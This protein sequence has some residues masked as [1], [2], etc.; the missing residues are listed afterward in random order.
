M[1]N[2]NNYKVSVSPTPFSITALNGQVLTALPEGPPK[3]KSLFEATMHFSV[4]TYSFKCTPV[5]LHYRGNKFR[6]IYARLHLYECELMLMLLDHPR[7]AA[8]AENVRIVI[9]TNLFLWIALWFNLPLI[10]EHN[11]TASAT[12]ILTPKQARGK[13]GPNDIPLNN[14]R[15]IVLLQ[16]L[17][18]T[19]ITRICQ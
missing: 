6:N 18:P 8:L 17:T 1:H 3:T 13:G 9:A 2:N 11:R 7:R 15:V 4:H 19:Q 10:Y 12:G 14:G 16:T 5:E